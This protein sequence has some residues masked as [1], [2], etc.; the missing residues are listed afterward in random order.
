[1]KQLLDIS[2][3]GRHVIV[4]LYDT[5]F[6]FD[7][8]SNPTLETYN[9]ILYE[10]TPKKV[11]SHLKSNYNSDDSI[12]FGTEATA[13]TKDDQQ[14]VQAVAISVVNATEVWCAVAR[15]DKSLTIYSIAVV[16]NAGK[17]FHADNTQIFARNKLQ[18]R[19]VHRTA[20]RVSSLSFATV[21]GATPSD[22]SITVVVA[23]DVV[24]D[25]T[26]YSL[27]IEDTERTH[28]DKEIKNDADDLQDEIVT[29][30]RRLLL[31]HTASM[32]TSVHVVEEKCS[33]QSN[34]NKKSIDCRPD[35]QLLLTSDRDEKIRVSQFPE[36]YRIE[37]FLLGHTAFV[38]SVAIFP[39][40]SSKHQCL[41]VGG[42]CTIRLW[43][44][45]TCKELACA[46][47][48]DESKTTTNDQ[49]A[50]RDHDQSSERNNDQ[51]V[52]CDNDQSAERDNKEQNNSIDPIPTKVAVSTDGSVIATIYDDCHTMD[53]WTVNNGKI[54]FIIEQSCSWDCSGQPLGIAFQNKDTFFILMQEPNYLLQYILS[55]DD[56]GTTIAQIY[57]RNNKFSLKILALAEMKSI[58]MPDGLL[59]KDEYGC[60]KMSKMSERRGGAAL[61]PWNNAARKETNAE[62]IRRLRKRRREEYEKQRQ[63]T[64]SH[65][66]EAE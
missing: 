38:S 35:R 58:V 16:D 62:R 27:L 12:I 29:K 59:E 32:L 45:A 33:E 5:V 26:A 53:F 55:Y 39:S 64:P 40:L 17:T 13:V 9:A 28:T 48:K 19:T 8:T 7:D 11:V 25:A 37:G 61:Q 51:T 20:K 24:G 4:G 34:I 44:F 22:P 47:T 6:Y 63:S 15:Y 23:G 65:Q 49:S 46:S 31:G 30:H 60:L 1:M 66:K 42:D 18:P 54:D 36:T 14:E 10:L 3:D 56:D 57:I 52:E 50:E 2:P 43:D 21:Y 41:S